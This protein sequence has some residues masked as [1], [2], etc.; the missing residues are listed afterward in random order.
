M[1]LVG[2][3]ILKAI[4]CEAE[5][6]EDDMAWHSEHEDGFLALD[7]RNITAQFSF[8]DYALADGRFQKALL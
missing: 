7:L 6:R 8:V 4:F 2:D 1:Y 5:A 3:I